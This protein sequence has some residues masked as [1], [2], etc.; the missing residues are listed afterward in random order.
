MRQEAPWEKHRV[1]SHP[2]A[3]SKTQIEDCNIYDTPVGIAIWTSDNIINNCNFWGCKDEGIAL[4]GTPYSNCEN[5]KISNCIFHDNCDGIELQY[6]SDNIITNCEFYDNTHTGIDAITSSNDR[7]II[8]NCKIYNNEV[9]GIYLSSSSDNQIIDCTI[10]DNKDGNIVMTKHSYNN[11]I[12]NTDSNIEGEKDNVN[13]RILT[14]MRLFQK[15]IFK[16]RT[17]LNILLDRLKSY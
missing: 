12:K 7:N 15:R 3:F 13:D 8:S 10:S 17:M 4:M 2:D 11:E 14:F 9:N 5:N 6:S 16:V 1:I